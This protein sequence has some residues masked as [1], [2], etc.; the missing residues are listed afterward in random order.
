M[1]KTCVHL[2]SKNTLAVA[3]SVFR[4]WGRSIPCKQAYDSLAL[5]DKLEIG[6]AVLGKCS[7]SCISTPAFWLPAKEAALL[8][9][10]LVV[11][12]ACEAGV[13]GLIL[14]R[15]NCEIAWNGLGI[16]RHGFS[17]QP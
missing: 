16:P 6:K 11:S 4:T 5:E 12:P 7:I 2:R 1:L 17:A 9:E 8:E 13:A 3:A 10:D 14:V 15:I